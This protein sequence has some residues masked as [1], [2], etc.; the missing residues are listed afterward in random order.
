MFSA[1]SVSVLLAVA[2]A[3]GPSVSQ[4]SAGG[5]AVLPDGHELSSMRTTSAWNLFSRPTP[6]ASN[7]ASTSVFS[8]T[9]GTASPTY[10]PAHTRA[11]WL[12]FLPTGVPDL[13]TPIEDGVRDL[14]SAAARFLS[15]PLHALFPSHAKSS[16][17]SPAPT[18]D[19]GVPSTC[20][21]NLFGRL[22]CF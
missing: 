3:T 11:P 22:E 6:G 1:I 9:A 15:G 19:P 8:L 14:E 21:L 5:P 17:A 13:V 12:G 7:T 20:E 16:R 4:S 10:R 18:P 2:C